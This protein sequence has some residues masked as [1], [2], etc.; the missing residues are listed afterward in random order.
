MI[1][2]SRVGAIVLAGAAVLYVAVPSALQVRHTL[3]ERNNQ[4]VVKQLTVDPVTLSSEETSAVETVRARWAAAPANPIVLTYHD[5]SPDSKSEFTVTPQ[6]FQAHMTALSALGANSLSADEF[7][8]WTRGEPVPERSVL[9]TFDDGARGVWK[10]ADDVLKR[11][12]FKATAFIITGFVG[13]NPPYYMTWNEIDA[14]AADGRWSIEAHSHL[15]HRRLAIDA[16]GGEGSFFGNLAW[17]GAENRLETVAEFDSRVRNDLNQSVVELR[18][19]GFGN[20]EMFAYPFSDYGATGNDP[21]VNPTLT[22]ATR[23]IFAIAF[24][25]GRRPLPLVGPFQINRLGVG[26]QDTTAG[27]MERLGETIA[28]NAASSSA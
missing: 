3:D 10:Y 19:R 28:L 18:K 1:N 17:L 14:L 6:Q 9:I 13:A 21:N 23:D 11:H 25:D 15:G 4:N 22:R 12:G 5:V 8:G 26:G 24:N 2:R 20:A 27:L 7:A 16:N